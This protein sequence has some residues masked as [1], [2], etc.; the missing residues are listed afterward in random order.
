MFYQELLFLFK[1]FAYQKCANVMAAK[2]D[3]FKIYQ[4]TCLHENT[5]KLR[6][7]HLYA[8][9]GYC[10]RPYQRLRL[11]NGAPFSH[12]LRHAG[13]TEDVFSA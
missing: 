2:C 10:F 8:R 12:L 5:S 1:I 9:L 13:D 7:H 6:R 3:Y 11:Y 4:N